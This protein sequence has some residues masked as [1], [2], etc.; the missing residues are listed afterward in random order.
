MLVAALYPPSMRRSAVGFSFL[1]LVLC[2]GCTDRGGSSET[3]PRTTVE[4]GG[5][6]SSP[7]TT[8][9][10]DSEVSFKTL[11]ERAAH[12]ATRL[13]SGDVL[14]VGG[15]V[16]DGCSAATVETFIVSSD[17]TSV[18]RGPDLS[19]PRDGHT[20]HALANGSVVLIAGYAGEGRPPLASIEVFD[21]ESGTIRSLAELTVPRGGHA[22]AL[23]S[24]D[25]VLVVGGWI[26]RRTF[27][28]SA[29]II[30][31]ATGSVFEA[32]PL[33]VA[34]HAMDAVALADGRVLV[35][36]G[37]VDVETG[38]N[39]AW[40]Y[41]SS[42]DAWSET[43]G[44]ADRRF[45]HLSV[46]LPDGRVLVIGGTTDDREILSTTEIYD[47]ASGSFTAGP[48][49]L[50]PRYKLPGGAVAVAAGKVFVGG[51]GRT[52]EAL[53]VD[54]GISILIEDLETQGSFATTTALGDGLILVLGG[55]DQS[56]D[57]RRRVR[58]VPTV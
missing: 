9:G 6:A 41:D 36:G 42:S 26:A 53:D 27:S 7:D 47:P 48:D 21:A 10:R 49:L 39:R 18:V 31:T 34:L 4:D 58:I 13:S 33:P 35:T 28:S 37:Q 24:G 14:V 46:I 8:I 5:E 50:E 12:T 57:L 56:I 16:T 19:G 54:E 30:D 23:L 3:N 32:A 25:R 2:V 55:Y 1:C 43:G 17:G 51:G 20:A 52:I 22:S 45:K 44:M 11:S 29:E 40:L 15:C 38:T